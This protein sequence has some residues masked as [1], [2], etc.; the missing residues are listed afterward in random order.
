MTATLDRPVRRGAGGGLPARRAMVRWALRMFRREWRRQLLV[1]VLL[2]VVVAGSAFA[3][4][5]VYQSAPSS[6]ARFGTASHLLTFDGADPARLRARLDA[7]AGYY[8][9]VE[10]VGHRYVPVP[11]L[12]DPIDV[13]AQHPAGVYS[14]P[15]LALQRGRYPTASGEV[16]L[17]DEVARTLHAAVGGRVVLD[18]RDREVVGLVENP[19]DLDDEFALV[20]APTA[21]PPQSVTVFVPG[22]RADLEAFRAT[23]DGV[24]VRESR[25]SESRA[26]L[27]VLALAVAAIGLLLVSLVAAAGFIVI[28]QRRQRQLGMLAAIGATPR[29]LRLVM[30]ANGAAV[31]VAA[32]VA[33]STVG[34]GIWLALAGRVETAAGHRIDR[35]DVPWQFVGAGMALAVLTATAAAWWPARVVAHT[36]V[37]SALSARPPRPRPA[38]RSA[39]LAVALLAAGV[40]ALAFSA[41]GARPVP[42]IGGALAVAAGLLLIGPLALRMLAA[43]RATAPVPV[44]LALTDLVRYQGRSAA[45]LAAIS[46]TLAI[47]AALV[48]GSAAAE[49][50][51]RRAAALGNLAGSQLMVRIGEPAPVVPDHTPAQLAAFESAAG[52]IADTIGGAALT[53]LDM[54]VVAAY[55]EPGVNGGHPAVELGIADDRLPDGVLSSYS[56]YVAT[57]ELLRIY[58]LA[59]PPAGVDLLTTHTG[60]IELVNIPARG[61]YPTIAALPNLGYSSTPTALL[62]PAVIARNGWRPARVGWFVQGRNTINPD[63]IDRVR[64]IAADAGLTV[65][66]RREQA[67]AATLR[68]GAT[69]A[70]V[71]LAL[72]VLAGTVGLIR[73][74]SVRDMRILAASGATRRV[75]RT[76]TAATSGTLAALGALLGVAGAH[77]ALLAVFRTDLD[78]LHDI[79]VAN[80]AILLFG[81]PVVATTTGWLSAAPGSALPARGGLD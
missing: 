21:D 9:T 44:R 73:G 5:A 51:A 17:T 40:V 31:G 26:V 39:A 18:G 30:L 41:G 71:L 58:G 46:L 54:A 25:P 20:D 43:G 56:A 72:G 77:L 37:M 34:L 38:R 59:A 29:Q 49:R 75:R 57:P 81:L 74:E 27:A 6:D 24:V 48:V 8:D 3:V 60:E 23:L 80:L 50:T 13:R 28:A 52:E 42:V 66:F 70:G 16:A 55:T 64:A 10:T 36:P 47:A 67:S 15:M 22:S 79:P 2:G 11:G 14:A 63:D 65:E 4:T 32:A 33:G 78:A 35:F 62:T 1:L 12:F 69:V 68:A 19:A 45:A 76:V 61:V 53:P 7:V